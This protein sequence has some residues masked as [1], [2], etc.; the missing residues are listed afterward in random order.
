VT[1]REIAEEI[2]ARGPSGS[3]PNS[4]YAELYRLLR[5]KFLNYLSFRTSEDTGEDLL[6]ELYT[7]LR[8]ALEQDRIEDLDALSAYARGMARNIRS[9]AMQK[10]AERM[11]KVKII[12]IGPHLK[13]RDDVE[14][15]AIGR[16][17]AAELAG[18]FQALLAELDPID[19]SLVERFYFRGHPAETIQ[20][21]L[22][23]GPGQFRGRMERLRARLKS[24]YE[25]IQRLSPP[26]GD[27]AA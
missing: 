22:G 20:A 25:R 12:P 11:R 24:D 27:R 7:R 5:A 19:R 9:R 26:D 13:A 14:K 6:Q 18:V 17:E 23:L 3:G 15:E 8:V 1:E 2:R 16:E 21:D 4:A 10:Q